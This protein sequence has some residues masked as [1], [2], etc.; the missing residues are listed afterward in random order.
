MAQTSVNNVKLG[1]R[2]G[3]RASETASALLNIFDRLTSV[4]DEQRR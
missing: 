3:A 2:P 4:E 1:R